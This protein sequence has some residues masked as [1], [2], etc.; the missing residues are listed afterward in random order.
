MPRLRLHSLR[1]ESFAT[2]AS[3]SAM[4]IIRLL[5]SVILTRIL[6]PEAYG[7][8]VMLSSI[9]FTLEMLSDIGVTGLMVRSA[10]GDEPRFINTLWTLRLI[11]NLVNF[12]I[13]YAA[14]PYV[15]EWYDSPALEG[16][17]RAFSW[18]FILAG[19][20]SMSF[21]LALRHQNSRIVS[22]TD[23]ACTAV[24]AVFVILYSQVSR[25][26]FGMVYGMVLNR[27]L[28]TGMSFGFS[29]HHRH[30]LVI[31]RDARRELWGFTKY[32]LPSSMITLVTTQF[33]KIIFLKLFNLQLL[34]LY[35]LAISIAGPVESLV[36]RMS[37]FVLYAR[38]VGYHR[39]DPSTVRE[40]YYGENRK[41]FFLMSALPA[42]IGGMA[43]FLV[44]FL[45]DPRYAFAATITLAFAF[46]AFLVSLAS[47][48]EDLL[49]AR[50]STKVVLSGNLIRLCW[51]IP[52]ALAG[53]TVWGFKGFLLGVALESLPTYLYLLHLQHRSQLLVV[54]MELAKL[55]F[56]ATV[57][58]L[59]WLLS[60]QLTVYTA[61]LRA[62]IKAQLL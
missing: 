31:D 43:G 30:R 45:Y 38:C 12:G 28:T 41:L 55:G 39:S 51:S 5:S 34:G 19:L 11:R 2:I 56:A 57:F 52:A 23:L 32:V 46:K 40:R 6:Y 50:G 36:V 17:L 13:F 3:F 54:R 47:P 42:L 33:D 7:I 58:S 25:D 16:A 37:R 14:T 62:L 1:G 8:V 24:S 48:I 49:V 10:H 15:A 4:S 9:V 53:Y 60:Q 26:H 59:S 22:F 61:P 21:M 29:R 27:A 18:Y 35:G 44:N 20:E